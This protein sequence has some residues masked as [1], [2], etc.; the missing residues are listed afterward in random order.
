MRER[1]GSQYAKTHDA[2]DAPEE[3]GS[4]ARLPEGTIQG[5]EVGYPQDE[6]HQ[7]EAILYCARRSYVG[8]PHDLPFGFGRLGSHERDHCNEDDNEDDATQDTGQTTPSQDAYLLIYCTHR[9]PPTLFGDYRLDPN[10]LNPSMLTLNALFVSLLL[11]CRLS[12]TQG[13]YSGKGCLSLVRRL[14]LLG[15]ENHESKRFS[16]KKP[17]QDLTD[18]PTAF[19]TLKGL[20]PEGARSSSPCGGDGACA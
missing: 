8:E 19:S 4:E 2:K 17:L 6:D 11:S 14:K 20:G 16:E 3:S 15:L 12:L 5:E 10:L 13:P 1:S 9:F 18:L 7:V